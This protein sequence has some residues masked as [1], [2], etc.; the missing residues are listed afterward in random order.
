MPRLV[1][2][3]VVQG[4][5]VERELG[6]GA[7]G[8]VYLAEDELLGRRVALKVVATPAREL[9]DRGLQ[10]ARVV[11][12]VKSPSI[13]TLYRVHALDG[14]QGWL[15]EMEYVGGGSLKE[16]LAREGRLAAPRAVEIARG[17]LEGLRCA[18][19]VGIVHGDIK[20]GNVL[21]EQTGAVK[22]AD[23]GLSWLIDDGTISSIGSGPVGTPAYMAPEVVL[24][25]RNR[26][27]SDLWGV[28]VVLY[29]MLAGR[30]PFRTARLQDFFLSVVN[31]EPPPLPPGIPPA[32]Q[33]LIGRLLSKVPSDRPSAE[34]AFKALVAPLADEV[35]R[36]VA[37][38]ARLHA[39]PQLCGR[40]GETGVLK[41]VLDRLASGE[42]AAL[43]VSGEAGVGK[44]ALMQWM[45]AEATARG[46]LAVEVT[47]SRLEGAVR[48]LLAGARRIVP[49][50]FTVS[51]LPGDVAARL[52]HGDGPWEAGTRQQVVWMVAQIFETIGRG[53]PLVIAVENAQ[54]ADLEDARLLKDL[55]LHLPSKGVLMSVAFRTHDSD[56]SSAGAAAAGLHEIAA[57]GGL[58]TLELGPL[59]PEAIHMLLEQH[60]H[61]SHIEPSVAQRLVGFANGNPLLAIEMLHHLS[62][63]GSVVTDG[64]SLR[65]SAA[66]DGATLPARFHELVE[67]RLAGL[68]EAQRAL[69]DAAAVD[70][71][72]FDGEALEAVLG[73]PLLDI[74][75]DLQRLYRER[76]LV[77]PQG[78]GYRFTSPLLQEVLYEE[79]A[80]ALRRAIHRKL[81][82]HLEQRGDIVDAGRIGVHWEQAGLPQRAAPH[83]MRAAAAAARRQEKLRLIDL[84]HR[85]GV[86]PGKID[87]E[88]AGGHLDTLL[89][90][91][92]ALRELG[93]T[94]EMERVYDD[95]LAGVT[96]KEGR[97]RIL[98]RRSLA[99][100]YTRGVDSVDQAFLVDAAATLPLSVEAGNAKMLL[101][102]VA[103]KQGRLAEAETAF[104]AADADFRA[105]GDDGLRTATVNQIAALAMRSE[106]HRDAEELYREAG[107]LARRTGRPIN[108]AIADVNRALA[109]LKGGRLEGLDT[110]VETALRTLMMAGTGPV[111][112][113]TILLAGVLYAQGRLAD[114]FSRVETGVDLLR[115][116]SDLH[117]TESV[118]TEEAHL[119]AVQGLLVR[120]AEALASAREAAARS[121]HLMGRVRI[122]CIEAQ[123]RCMEGDGAAAEAA[124]ARAIELAASTEERAA[125]HEPA[126]WLSEAVLY[127]LPT[128]CLP[129]DPHPF[130]DA[131]RA[132]GE[133]GSALHPPEAIPGGRRA[134]LRLVADLWAA[135]ALRR[136]GRTEAAATALRAV[137]EGARALGHVWLA[138]ASMGR[139]HD[140][141][142][143][144]AV[145]GER[146]L[147]LDV[148][149]QRTPEGDA[150]RRLQDAW[151]ARGA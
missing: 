18:H 112:G 20:P 151:G 142:G 17:V 119:G 87:P 145:A 88:T 38:P 126:F 51:G 43:L 63:M 123:L 80:P 113:A 21:L 137:V 89:R 114:A 46:M 8:T 139:L 81:A 52:L 72:L 100:Y 70:G 47:V 133:P 78:E 74:L 101:G 147:L 56:S 149:V 4:L 103:K 53:R 42:G 116:Y 106:R 85:A 65:S 26:M 69:L 30:L 40:G 73:R 77:E 60:T 55:L 140:W 7:F 143:D 6:R 92:A 131:A 110:E 104:R 31:A 32:L 111:P 25:E 136:S 124:A 5:R 59:T 144:A 66:W 1:P 128:R 3:S 76:R 11:A 91:A 129:P 68:P 109:A 115:Q 36:A 82:E 67:R 45:L 2:G 35:V 58:R 134:T 48:P 125:R 79:I 14:E 75:R 96:Q 97:C 34:E 99:H 9:R 98:V 16:L 33:R 132:F 138:L 44:S 37:E 39:G 83:L 28:G 10:E 135:E 94:D 22:L 122:A 19:E 86:E 146:S 54:E 49:P 127:G 93:R 64:S 90:L 130:A 41:G 105:I 150:R 29:E 118:R 12:R 121:G 61:A 108:A 84:C 27:P 15:L 23:F 13:V 62:A 24:G 107:A 71:R 148:V 102:L 57:V 120:A 50:D 117:S 141:T 95:M